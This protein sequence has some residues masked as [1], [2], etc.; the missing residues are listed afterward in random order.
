MQ[1]THPLFFI[2]QHLYHPKHVALHGIS[3]FLH[4]NFNLS[5]IILTSH[6]VK[7]HFEN[8]YLTPFLPCFTY[9]LIISHSRAQVI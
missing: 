1:F 7:Q 4:S 2:A 3:S 6:T 5:H 8:T 9:D